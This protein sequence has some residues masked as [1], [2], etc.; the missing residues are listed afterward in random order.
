MVTR[1]HVRAHSRRYVRGSYARR[2]QESNSYQ[3]KKN[4]VYNANLWDGSCDGLSDRIWKPRSG[5]NRK[6]DRIQLGGGPKVSETDI[7][8][9]HTFNCFI[10]FKANYISGND[11]HRREVQREIPG[12]QSV[13][14][15]QEFYLI[16]LL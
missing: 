2:A 9:D 10:M 5:L 4:S 8:S 6:Y 13:H 7:Y 1:G 11:G 16:I 15:C 3:I 14:I 12:L